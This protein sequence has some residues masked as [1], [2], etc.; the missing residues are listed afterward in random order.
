M[1]LAGISVWI[2]VCIRVGVVFVSFLWIWR[3][4]HRSRGGCGV[5]FKTFSVDSAWISIVFMDLACISVFLVWISNLFARFGVGF[6]GFCLIWRVFRCF[7]RDLMWISLSCR[8][9]G[10]DVFVFFIDVAWVSMFFN[11]F[12]VGF[13]VAP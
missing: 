2:L 4:F 3:G 8:G 7:S 11:G 5:D 10:V 1:A 9:F 6:V 12:G 13:S